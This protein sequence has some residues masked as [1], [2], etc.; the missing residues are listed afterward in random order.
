MTESPLRLLLD[1]DARVRRDQEQPPTFLH[2]RDRK[3]ALTCRDNGLTPG[4]R[5]SLIHI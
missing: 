5:L 1:F 3:F 4:P 2:R